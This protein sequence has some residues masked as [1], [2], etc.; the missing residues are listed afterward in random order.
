MSELDNKVDSWDFEY[1]QEQ[2]WALENKLR[3]SD[4]KIEKLQKELNDLSIKKYT[5]YI[6]QFEWDNK[7]K[8]V[9]CGMIWEGV[10]GYV[11]GNTDCPVQLKVT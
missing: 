10:M 3:K 1:L 9:K 8:C 5:K 4:E 11:C 6:N 7:V 2:V